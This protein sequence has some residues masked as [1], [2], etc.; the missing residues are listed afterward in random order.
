MEKIYLTEVHQM[1]QD[2]NYKDAIEVLESSPIDS[3]SRE[4]TSL[5]VHCYN[6]YS[7]KLLQEDN[8]P[9]AFELL[10]KAESYTTVS[11]LLR[12]KTLS[13]I[14]CCLKKQSKTLAA[15]KYLEKA[16]IAK[17]SGD[18]HMNI[19]AV[20]SM[21]G[22]HQKALEEAMYAIILLQDDFID[23]IF[24]STE[25]HQK[26]CE[27][28]AISYHNLAVEFEFL[29]RIP[30]SI[31]FYRK[32]SETFEKHSLT[33]SALN[34]KLKKD[35]ENAI[36]ASYAQEKIFR[37][38]EH[39]SAKFSQS[40]SP[41]NVKN[42]NEDSSKRKYNF[43][44][45][46]VPEIKKHSK[47]ARLT[48]SELNRFGLF[49]K[50]TVLPDIDNPRNTKKNISQTSRVNTIEPDFPANTVFSDKSLKNP[51]ENNDYI[52]MLYDNFSKNPHI[53]KNSASNST[54]VKK[55]S[56]KGQEI[57]KLPSSEN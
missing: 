39:R 24:V 51:S 30:E 44:E 12:S 4:R 16:L 7:I 31:N 21:E 20:L 6:E 55:F 27:T 19:C 38:K 45:D 52:T 41:M 33:S 23:S 32:A 5:L 15:L 10:R 42:Y 25:D 18:I 35:M 2:E 48:P 22:K 50:T 11:S 49:A 46:I 28:L 8:I 36:K 26:R 3:C 29:K 56:F 43:F 34:E 37:S 13:N 40:K 53:L 57:S 1:I 17:P 9:L 47:D 14:A 54:S